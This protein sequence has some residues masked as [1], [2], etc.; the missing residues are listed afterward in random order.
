MLDAIQYED[1]GL[2]KIGMAVFF[3]FFALIYGFLGVL[4][5][6]IYEGLFYYISDFF[7]I[8]TRWL[9]YRGKFKP[10]SN[11][12]KEVLAYEI[13]KSNF[14]FRKQ[15]MLKLILSND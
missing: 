9:L 14:K 8:K 3:Y 4:W 10:L 5:L 13:E 12:K 15:F 11:Y 2:K 1:S 6:L 7:F